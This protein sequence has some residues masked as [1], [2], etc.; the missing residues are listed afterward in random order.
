MASS[1]RMLPRSISRI[2]AWLTRAEDLGLVGGLLHVAKSSR[3]MT[4]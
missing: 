2:V 3:V 1:A 4:S